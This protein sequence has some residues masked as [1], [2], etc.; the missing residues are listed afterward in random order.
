MS[1]SKLSKKAPKRDL[2]CVDIETSVHK[3]G[4]SVRTLTA[5]LDSG[6]NTCIISNDVVKQ[7]GLSD[8]VIKQTAVVHAFTGAKSEFKGKISL[9]FNI[10]PH[11]F[12][13]MFQVI[14]DNLATGTDC[15]LGIDFLNSAE[16]VMHFKP[17]GPDLAIGGKQIPVK[18]RL[19]RRR[20]NGCDLVNYA[21]RPTEEPL[22]CPT[23][24]AKSSE[25]KLINPCTAQVIRVILPGNDWPEFATLRRTKTDKILIEEQLIT[26]RKHVP[27]NKV[28]C[29]AL[30]SDKKCV[31]G[32][33][34][35]HFR[36]A[37]AL[38]YNPS[39]RPIYLNVGENIGEVEPQYM[40]EELTDTVK[41]QID[42]INKQRDDE[43]RKDRAAAAAAVTDRAEQLKSE[44]T[45]AP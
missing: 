45:R 35:V 23:M 41:A 12:Q 27:S 3:K 25:F 43:K 18:E 13:H 29:R 14:E 26:V 39:S 36:Y 10:G 32:C 19:R 20:K 28:K 22:I 37:L 7:L 6:A 31:V 40:N 4:K 21:A 24:Y 44:L 1:C 33:P 38:V 30:C 16:I 2:I 15:L 11:V 8:Q 42:V 17:E 9:K 5:L 34:T